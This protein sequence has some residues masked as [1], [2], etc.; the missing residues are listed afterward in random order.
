MSGFIFCS[1]PVSYAAVEEDCTSGL[2]IEVFDDSDK[3]GADVLL[4][5]A[6]KAVCQT[7][8]K[9][10]LKSM[11]TWWRSCGAGDIFVSAY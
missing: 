8:L 7:L 10:F 9:V 3:V 1:E 2:V 5:V 11:K 4:H 6:L